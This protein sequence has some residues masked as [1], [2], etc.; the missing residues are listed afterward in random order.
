MTLE[1]KTIDQALKRLDPM[2]FLDKRWSAFSGLYYC[3]CRLMED[4]SAPLVA[5]D[6]RVGTHARPLS[7]DLV[8]QVAAQE[9]SI[10]E[11]IAQATA[12]NA[13]RKELLRQERLARQDEAIEDWQKSKPGKVG[14][15]ITTPL[16]EHGSES[17]S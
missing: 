11:S 5:V 8:N 14:V 1:E 10:T 16:A 3:A 4:G 2:L 17:A 7:H 13:A 9:G 15:V 6:W 12:H